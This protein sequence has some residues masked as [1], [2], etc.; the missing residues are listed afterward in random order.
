MDIYTLTIVTCLSA[1][2]MALGMGAMYWASRGEP[3]LRDWALA[4]LLF[5]VNSLLVFLLNGLLALFAGD[6]LLVLALTLGVGNAC[7]VAGHVVVLSGLR[8]HLGRPHCLDWALGVWVLLVVAHVSPWASSVEARLLLTLPMMV[9]VSLTSA[10]TILRA[11]GYRMRSA[12]T[13]LLVVELL[14]ALQLIARILLVASNIGSERQ[15]LGSDLIQTSGRLSMFMYIAL[16]AACCALLVTRKQALALRHHAE[17]DPMTGW[18]NRWTLA[19]VLGAEFERS[20]RTNSGF[21]LVTVDIDHFK[22]INDQYGHAVG[23]QAIRHVTALVAHE[24]RGYDQKFRIGGEEFVICVPG[25]PGDVAAQVAERLRLRIERT[26]LTLAEG[27]IPITVS[28]GH[29]GALADDPDWE[30][31]LKRADLALYEAK[32]GGRN[33]VVSAPRQRLQGAWV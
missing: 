13:A 32:Q 26:P 20:R 28:V 4:G 29:A 24:L 25:Q 27:Q 1:S 30:A 5:F 31:V 17:T 7:T 12:L 8:R 15:L 9:V 23:D 19:Q 33:R 2:F 6:K 21:H 3:A 16:S 10:V 11:P 14:F 22:H 18:L